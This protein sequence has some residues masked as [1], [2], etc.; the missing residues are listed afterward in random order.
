M[1]PEV[2]LDVLP[3]VLEPLDPVEAEPVVADPVEAEPVIDWATDVDATDVTVVLWAR[4]DAA[5]PAAL[6]AAMAP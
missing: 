4:A 2:L 6:P 5:L 1:L 3:V